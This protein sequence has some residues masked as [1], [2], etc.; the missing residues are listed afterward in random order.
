MIIINSCNFMGRMIKDPEV[1]YSNAAEPVAVA[2]FTLAVNRRFKKDGQPE[3]DFPQFKA[4]GKTA[5]VIEKY[6]K[7][8]DQIG[9]IARFQ[10][11]TWDKDDGT[12][13]YANEFLVESIDFGAKAG[14]NKTTSESQGDFPTNEEPEDDLPF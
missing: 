1:R 13:G 12:K 8:G 2:N 9:V 4:F 11:R 14:S 7:K 5:E 10:T 3:A 6:V